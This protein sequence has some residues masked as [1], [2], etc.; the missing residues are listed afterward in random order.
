MKVLEG[1]DVGVAII[2]KLQRGYFKAPIYLQQQIKAELL[3]LATLCESIEYEINEKAFAPIATNQK[4][5]LRTLAHRYH[6][7]L[8][9]EEKHSVYD[10]SIPRA[11]TKTHISN[12]LITAA[13]DI[14]SGDLADQEVSVIQFQ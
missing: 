4:E 6:C 5:A 1:K 2:D 13:I 12:E 11:I 10:C 8:N 7:S 14:R 3:R 9:I